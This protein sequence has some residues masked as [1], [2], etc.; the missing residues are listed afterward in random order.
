MA[1]QTEHKWDNYFLN[2][3]QTFL[4]MKVFF[5]YNLLTIFDL[6]TFL[7]HLHN[8]HNNNNTLT[9]TIEYSLNEQMSQQSLLV[10]TGF[11]NV[12]GKRSE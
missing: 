2:L 8:Y 1:I 5:P 7:L 9:V 11:K 3:M 6:R 12:S 4:S 10:R